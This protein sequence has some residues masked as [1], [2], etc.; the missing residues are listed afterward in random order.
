MIP[1]PT[2]TAS[3]FEVVPARGSDTEFFVL[4]NRE[5][6]RSSGYPGRIGLAD[7]QGL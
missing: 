6:Y 2:S 5:L 7:L 1:V 4:C 3:T